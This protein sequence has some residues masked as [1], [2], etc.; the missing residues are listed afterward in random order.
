MLLRIIQNIFKECEHGAPHQC[1]PLA[2]SLPRVESDTCGN[3]GVSPAFSYALKVQLLGYK[4]HILGS[5]KPSFMRECRPAGM[6]EGSGEEA[7]L[8]AWG[9]PLKLSLRP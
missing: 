5:L 1:G 2:A 6:A 4:G 8:T 7:R 9:N 3:S